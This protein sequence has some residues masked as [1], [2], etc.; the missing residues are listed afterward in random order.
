M[1]LASSGTMLDS[2]ALPLMP[3][4]RSD[5]PSSESRALEIASAEVRRLRRGQALGVEHRPDETGVVGFR[6]QNAGGRLEERLAV[7]ERRGALVGRDAH[8]LEDVGPEQ[9]AVVIGERVERLA[10]ADQAGG[11]CGVGEGAVRPDADVDGRLRDSRS[12]ECGPQEAHVRD[13]VIGD[14]AGVGANDGI[15]EG[16]RADPRCGDRALGARAR[17]VGGGEAGA[18]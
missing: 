8:V 3:W 6:R 2:V 18:E 17:Q 16:N 12:P 7:D 11:P 9:E 10:R 13:L 15:G 5:V 14:F 1:P 4:S